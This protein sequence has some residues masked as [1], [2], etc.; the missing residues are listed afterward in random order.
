MYKSKEIERQEALSK[1]YFQN[2]ADFFS[3]SGIRGA[4]DAEAAK[5]Y[6]ETIKKYISLMP[7]L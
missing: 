6:L 1:F 5:P 3:S 7:S 4:E 2:A